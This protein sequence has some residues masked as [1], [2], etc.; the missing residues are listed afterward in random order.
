MNNSLQKILNK[1]FP[2][3]FTERNLSKKLYGIRHCECNDGWY[4]VIRE[5]CED[6]TKLNI[7][8]LYLQTVKEKFGGLRIY[9]SISSEIIWAITERAQEES[10]KT[11]ED[12][13]SRNE[14]AL[15]KGGWIRSLCS[16]CQEARDKK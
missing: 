7:P 10:F 1:D 15:S 14:V 3:L 8:Q 11:C 4:D 16:K 2:N 12:C 6:L 5:A 13:G 9:T